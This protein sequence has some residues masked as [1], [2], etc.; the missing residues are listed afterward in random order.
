MDYFKYQHIE[1]LG[2]DEVDGIL[3][4]ECFVFPKLDGTNAQVWVEDNRLC[5]GSRNRQL[6]VESDNHGFANHVSSNEALCRAVLAFPDCR[7]FGEWLVPHTLKTY[8]ESAW[9]KFYIF[10]IFDTTTNEYMSY[11]HYAAVLN[12]L[13]FEDYVPCMVRGYNLTEQDVKNAA[14]KNRWL[15]EVG[16]GEGVVVKNYTFRNKYGRQTWAK[17]VLGEFKDKHVKAMG[18]TDIERSP[19]EQKI[20]D[21]FLSP[22]VIDKVISD[23]K[24]ADGW[25]GRQIPRLLNTVWNDFIHEEMWDIIKKHKNPT[26]D[27]KR[28]GQLCTAKIKEMKP[29]LF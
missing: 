8:R 4:G 20:V 3:N 1:R 23:I 22:H 5:C 26:I 2:S 25:S 7:I 6:S 10:D 16:L 14:E 17:Y 15:I 18:P 9:R 12:D 19:I 27:F 21:E 29:E 28:L 11:H 13:G 24:A